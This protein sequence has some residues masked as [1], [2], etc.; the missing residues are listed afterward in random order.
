VV[1]SQRQDVMLARA[2]L[3]RLSAVLRQLYPVRRSAA[4]Q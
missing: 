2:E 1:S 4:V 3:V